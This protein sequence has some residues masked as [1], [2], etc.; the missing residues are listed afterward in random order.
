MLTDKADIVLLIKAAAAA[1]IPADQLGAVGVFSLGHR[2]KKKGQET[3]PDPTFFTPDRLSC[4]RP[5]CNSLAPDAFLTS[6]LS[7]A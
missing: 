7:I 2:N 6:G 3:N 5:I 4:T 1:G